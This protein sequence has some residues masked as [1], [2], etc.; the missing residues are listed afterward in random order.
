MGIIT[1]LLMNQRGTQSYKLIS[2]IPM[3]RE[4]K[5]HPE[6]T[7]EQCVFLVYEFASKPVG[8]RSLVTLLGVL[9][10]VV[11]PFQA[12]MNFGVLVSTAV[13]IGILGDLMFMLY[14][15]LT[16]PRV[17]RLI[18]KSIDMRTMA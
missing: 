17:K 9:A 6:L 15:L 18:K 2:L 8:F 3:K 13:S 16:F 1:P 5:L 12:A 4:M 10:L 14:I 11:T 7:A